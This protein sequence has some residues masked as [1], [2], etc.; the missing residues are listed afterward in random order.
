MPDT[1]FPTVKWSQKLHFIALSV[2]VSEF[3]PEKINIT[4]LYIE[5]SG[6][7]IGAA[8]RN[9]YAFELNFFK[10]IET[11]SEL[12]IVRG[13]YLLIYNIHPRDRLK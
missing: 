5:F 12:F 4:K 1:L 13:L 10:E 11:E 9:K 7:G 3:V 8:G 6:T 2:Y